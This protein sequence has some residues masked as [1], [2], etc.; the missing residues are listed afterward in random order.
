M[1]R[2]WKKL[3]VKIIIWLAADIYLTLLGLDTLCSQ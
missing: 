1:H 2:K 3:F